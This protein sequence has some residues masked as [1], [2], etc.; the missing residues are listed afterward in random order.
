MSNNP[1]GK[2]G[3]QKG[4]SGNPKGRP[5]KDKDLAEKARVYTELSIVTLVEVCGDLEEKGSAR[6]AAARELLDRGWGKAP[7]V[8]NLEVEEKT[9][10]V[11]Y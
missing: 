7:Q 1:T 11:D 2:G 3:F 8:I 4:H 10:H 5:Q 9:K 6:V